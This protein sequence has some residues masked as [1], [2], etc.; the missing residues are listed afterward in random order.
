MKEFKRLL[1]PDRGFAGEIGAWVA[2]LDDCRRQTKEGLEGLSAE[3]LAWVPPAAGN[4]IGRLLRHIAYV[5]LEWILIDVCGLRERPPETPALLREGPPLADVGTRPPAELLALL[6]YARAETKRRLA[7][8]AATE[9][10][11]QRVY[12][13]EG[14]GQGVRK[15]FTVRWILYHLL[16]HEA[17]HK[18]QIAAVR[19]MLSLRGGAESRP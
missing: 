4:S 16:D 7:P 19:R 6:D 9:L 17:A 13:V 18:G 8:F 15:V 2:A 3:E 14:D 10:D 1:E 5:E 12:E 11:A